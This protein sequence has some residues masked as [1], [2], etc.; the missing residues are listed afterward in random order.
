CGPLTQF[1][2]S[3]DADCDQ[4]FRLSREP[5][6][7]RTVR[8]YSSSFRHHIG[9][10]EPSHFSSSSKL[11]GRSNVIPKGGSKSM[12]SVTPRYFFDSSMKPAIVRR[13]RD[14]GSTS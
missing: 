8:S 10:Q 11:K 3:N 6:G 5:C 4:V 7:D 2:E 1:R 12:P 14:F 13:R 9:V